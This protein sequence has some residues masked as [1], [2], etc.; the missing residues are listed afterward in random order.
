[1]VSL[2]QRAFGSNQTSPMVT[3]SSKCPC[4]SSPR[5]PA[6]GDAALIELVATRENDAARA[7][8]RSL[9]FVETEH[10]T[11]EFVGDMQDPPDPEQV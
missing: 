9:G 2:E 10:I 8:Y 7:F 6:A 11:L 3:S 1:M 5:R 4:S